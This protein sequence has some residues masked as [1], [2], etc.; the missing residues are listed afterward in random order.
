LNRK[1]RFPKEKA[2]LKGKMQNTQEEVQNLKREMVD[3]SND[4]N[5]LLREKE[6]N[7]ER[8]EIEVVE[9]KEEMEMILTHH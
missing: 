6:E 3:R 9:L 2:T 4:Q 1:K 8:L 5:T 7:I